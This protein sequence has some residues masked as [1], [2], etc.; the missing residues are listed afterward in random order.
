MPR[1]HVIRSLQDFDAFQQK[2]RDLP[3]FRLDGQRATVS[4]G[5]GTCLALKVDAYRLEFLTDDRLPLEEWM[6]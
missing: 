2:C 6:G 3:I 4:A 5:G 1:V